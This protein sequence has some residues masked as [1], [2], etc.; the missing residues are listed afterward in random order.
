VFHVK[1]TLVLG[2]GASFD[3]GFPLGKDLV[4]KVISFCAEVTNGRVPYITD[5][6]GAFVRLRKALT[7]YDPMSIDAFLYHYRADKKLIVA[8]KKSIMSVIL[9]DSKEHKFYRG[10]GNENWMRLLW[11]GLLSDRSAEE[12]ANDD[13]DLN[14]NVIT[15]NYDASLEHFLYSRITSE[16]SHFS[17]SEQS[18]ILDKLRGRIQH[19]Y[20]CVMD[21]EWT[22]GEDDNSLFEFTDKHDLMQHAHL[23]YNRIHLINER[24][25]IDNS[26]IVGALSG[27][28]QVIFLGFGFDDTNIGNRVLNLVHSVPAILQETSKGASYSPKIKYTNW[29]NSLVIDKKIETAIARNRDFSNLVAKYVGDE[30]DTGILKSTKSVVESLES[31]FNLTNF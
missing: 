22:G 27:S 14:F 7:F 5:D 3:F 4:D 24:E 2:A 10:S 18:K 17:E 12:L 13:F 28:Q 11:S 26:N 20:G 1:T 6:D 9:T 31:D 8:A 15:F 19:V 29:S 16:L 25:E 30:R 23:N 21:Y